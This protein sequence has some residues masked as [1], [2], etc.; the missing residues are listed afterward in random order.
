MNRTMDAQRFEALVDAYGAEPRR[1]PE[2][3]Q[4]AALAFQRSDRAAAER[5]LF[6]ARMIDAA[7]DASPAPR[8]SPALHDRIVAMAAVA[9]LRPRRSRPLV[10]S[11]LAWASGFGWAA[12]CAAGLIVG[13]NVSSQIAADTA[14][15]AVLYQAS[16]SGPDDTEVLG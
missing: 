1:W 15:E 10:K 8:V 14:A 13:V 16:L 3:E 4:A 9:G 6:S 5:I 11:P 7:L 2:P 12:A